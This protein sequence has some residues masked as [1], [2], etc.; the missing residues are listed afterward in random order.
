[1]TLNGM[2]TKPDEY[3]NQRTELE[4]QF[5]AALQKK[6]EMVNESLGPMSNMMTPISDVKMDIGE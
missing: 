2:A 5:T 6:Q 3:I 4:T 1:M